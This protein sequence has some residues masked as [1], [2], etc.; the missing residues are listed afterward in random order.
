MPYSTQKSSLLDNMRHLLRTQGYA[1]RTELTYCD[2]VERFITFHSI[3][4][5]EPLLVASEAKVEQFLTYLAV[6]KNVAPSTQNQAFN[7]L[8]FL[9]SKVLQVAYVFRR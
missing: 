4:S 3:Q 1:Y 8:V 2:W 5:C 9:Y 6:N 7:A